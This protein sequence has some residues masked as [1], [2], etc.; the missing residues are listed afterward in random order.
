M[1]DDMSG[2]LLEGVDQLPE[3]CEGKEAMNSDDGTRAAA[4]E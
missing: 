4:S 3:E 2:N 1:S